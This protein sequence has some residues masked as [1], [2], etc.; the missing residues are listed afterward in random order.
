LTN[1]AHSAQG[2]PWISYIWYP[3]D[4]LSGSTE[5]ARGAIAPPLRRPLAKRRQADQK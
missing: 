4:T 3:G 1:I 2:Y 5:G